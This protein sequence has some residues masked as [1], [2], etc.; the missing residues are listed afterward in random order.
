MKHSEGRRTALIMQLNTHNHLESSRGRVI[1]RGRPLHRKQLEYYN[2]V[3]DQ[4]WEISVTDAVALCSETK[5][6]AYLDSILVDTLSCGL[7]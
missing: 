3:A 4:R 2:H 7:I 5:C 1:R 6:A